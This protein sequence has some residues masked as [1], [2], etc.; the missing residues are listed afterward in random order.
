MRSYFFDN[1]II[2]HY[3]ILLVL[4]VNREWGRYSHLF[5]FFA[6]NDLVSALLMC[7]KFQVSKYSVPCAAAI[8]M[9]MAS[10]TQFGGTALEAIKFAAIDARID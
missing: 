4:R 7:L 5:Q 10:S 1:G 3:K 9:C 8:A 2:N 6:I